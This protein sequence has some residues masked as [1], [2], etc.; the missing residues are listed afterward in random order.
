MNLTLHNVIQTDSRGEKFMKIP[1]IY[2]RGIH[3]KYLRIPDDIMGYA[4]EQSMINM[5]NRNRYQKEEVLA[6]VVVVV[7]VVEV[8]IQEGLII[9][10]CM[11]IIMDV[12]ES[13]LNN[14]L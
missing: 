1:E 5:E 7:V 12:D 3:I 13:E 8:V 9:D 14:F 11:D 2:I 6:V 10:N 4:K